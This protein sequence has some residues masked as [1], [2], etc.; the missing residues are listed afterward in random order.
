MGS[1]LTALYVFFGLFTVGLIQGCSHSG[2]Q[3]SQHASTI[4]GKGNPAD[5]YCSQKGGKVQLKQNA[6]GNYSV[7]TFPDGLQI[8]TWDLYRE[9]H[10]N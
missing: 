5:V 2:Q 10:K 9:N 8:D 1:K 4:G 7:C 3:N 6:K